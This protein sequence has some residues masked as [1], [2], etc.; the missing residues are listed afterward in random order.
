MEGET[1][2]AD[3]RSDE[4]GFGFEEIPGDDDETPETATEFLQFSGGSGRFAQSRF[5]VHA[6]KEKEKKANGESR[7]VDE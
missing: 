1:G 3:A 6:E 5:H 4:R 2:N 7:T